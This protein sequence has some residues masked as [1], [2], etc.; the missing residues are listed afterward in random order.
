MANKKNIQIPGA[1]AEE[2][3]TAQKNLEDIENRAKNIDDAIELNKSIIA[4]DTASQ[5]EKNHAQI[6]LDALIDAKTLINS[7]LE[8]AQKALDAIKAHAQIKAATAVK[9]DL[10]AVNIVKATNKNIA[11]AHVKLTKAGYV[12]DAPKAGEK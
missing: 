5:D 10:S 6:K 7:T 9:T 4:D 1:P 8:E 12:V 2:Q 11:S 3:I